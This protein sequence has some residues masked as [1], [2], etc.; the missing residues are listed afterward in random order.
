MPKV[1][2]IYKDYCPPVFG[3]I[4]KHLSLLC[5]KLSSLAHVDVLVAN[6][7][8]RTEQ[9][10]INGI[11]VTKAGTLGRFFSA[12][13]SPLFGYYLGRERYDVLHFH[14]P[15]P[16]AVL[17]YLLVRPSGRIVVTW[18]S[19]IVRQARFLPRHPLQI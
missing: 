4:E 1:L 3:G 12:P 10:F 2:Q 7:R 11:K 16:T 8:L 14:L 18:H 17:S 15:N 19:D 13:L 5:N 6:R 9:D